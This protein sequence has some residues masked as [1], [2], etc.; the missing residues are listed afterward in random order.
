[1]VPWTKYVSNWKT[2][3]TEPNKF[4]ETVYPLCKCTLEIGATRLHS[5]RN[6]IKP[7]ET[8]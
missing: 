5:I 8:S 6:N 2:N 4:P 3:K 7:Q 1:M